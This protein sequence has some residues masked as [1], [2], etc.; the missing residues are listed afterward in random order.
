MSLM[1]VSVIQS[2]T[3]TKMKEKTTKRARWKLIWPISPNRG[4]TK[5]ISTKNLE[6]R[7]GTSLRTFIPSRLANEKSQK[8]KWHSHF[9]TRINHVQL[10]IKTIRL[11]KSKVLKN[12]KVTLSRKPLPILRYLT[13]EQLGMTKFS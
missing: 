6:L 10:Q 3:V 7:V 11:K 4:P 1:K 5:I 13:Q 9:R 12:L 8:R 2:Q